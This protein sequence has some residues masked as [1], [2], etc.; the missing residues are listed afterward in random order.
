MKAHIDSLVDKK[1]KK[2]VESGGLVY[3]TK[4]YM[5]DQILNQLKIDWHKD[6]Y[7]RLFSGIEGR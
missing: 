1:P 2:F 4:D 5:T 7:R 3:M 6:A